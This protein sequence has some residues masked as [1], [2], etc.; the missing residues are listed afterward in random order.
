MRKSALR[1]GA[2]LR[3][4]WVDAAAGPLGWLD[5]AE[6]D[7]RAGLIAVETVGKVVKLDRKQVVLAQTAAGNG[8]HL[9]VQA[10]PR[11][12]IAKIRELRW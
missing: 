1:K 9:N 11:A 10:I 4:E 7:E 6:I 12:W 5:D 8:D 2:W 3:V